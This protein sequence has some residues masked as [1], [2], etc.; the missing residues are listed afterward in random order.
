MIT[1][2]DNF[3]DL[4]ENKDQLAA[5][6]TSLNFK[7]IDLE[8]LTQVSRKKTNSLRNRYNNLIPVLWLSNLKF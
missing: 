7:Y 4:K 2:I 3:Q 1:L 8:K 5:S 6:L